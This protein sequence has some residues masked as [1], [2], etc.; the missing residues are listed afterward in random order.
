MRYEGA[1]FSEPDGTGL[2]TAYRFYRYSTG[3]H[4]YTI[5]TAERDVVINTMSH[6]FRYEGAGF[7]ASA[8]ATEAAS[9]AVYRF[10]DSSKGTHFFT[11]SECERDYVRTHLT[12]WGYEGI[13]YYERPL[14]ASPD[15][16]GALDS[17]WY[18]EAYP[19]VRALVNAGATTAEQHWTQYG[20]TQ[21]R[22]PSS[23]A[24]LAGNDSR[25]SAGSAPGTVT[26]STA[27]PATTH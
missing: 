2:A 1:V 12:N 10:Y 25:N 24:A 5:N 19:D 27:A 16:S 7:T 20:K 21:G 26:P 17:A 9:Q 6:L 13:A 11:A 15:R 23:L 18:L 14:P 22:L 3:S 4:F 8:T